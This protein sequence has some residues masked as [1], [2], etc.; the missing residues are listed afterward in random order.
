MGALGDALERLLPFLTFVVVFTAGWF[1]FVQARFDAYLWA[2]TEAAALEER[3][4]TMQQASERGQLAPPA[5]LERAQREFEARV[6]ADDKVADVASALAHAVLANAP[7]GMLRSLVIETGDRTSQTVPGGS[8]DPGRGYIAAGVDSADPRLAL[9]PH[10]VSYTPVRVTFE[11]TFEAAG[12]LLWQMRN[13]P[14]LVEVR[15]AVLTRGL[16]L[17]R[18]ELLVCVLQREDPTDAGTPVLPAATG[19][20][21]PG[22]TG[23]R[24]APPA[25]ESGAM[26]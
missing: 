7:A 5:D 23:P 21:A 10:T 8:A 1:W 9:F 20:A 13:L 16:P 17:M 6:S 22:Q 3:A 4:G 18:T 19:P 2:R 12:N 25:A 14:T 24:L 26:R 11:S 15:S